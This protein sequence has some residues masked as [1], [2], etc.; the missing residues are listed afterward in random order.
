MTSIIRS[1]GWVRILYEDFIP[2]PWAGEFPWHAGKEPHLN[3]PAQQ[4]RPPDRGRSARRGP[5]AAVRDSELTARYR[6]LFDHLR[7]ELRT[8]HY[9]LKTKKAYAHWLLHFLAFCNGLPPDGDNETAVRSFLTHL[10][11][12]CDVAASTQNQAL[13]ALVFVYREA[14]GRPLELVGEFGKAKRPRRL[15]TVLSLPEVDRLLDQ[16][17]ATNHLLAQLMYGAGLRI[18]DCI[19][20]RVKDLDFYLGQIVVQDGKGGKDRVTVLPECCR[21]LLQQHLGKVQVLFLAD[22]RSDAA[23]VFIWPAL[24][25]KYPAAGKKWVWQYVFPSPKLSQDL[26][27]GVIRRHHIHESKVQEAIAKAADAADIQKRV[28]THTLRHSFAT[29]LLEAGYDIRT[30]QELLGHKDVSTTMIYTHVM[31][32]PGIAVKSPADFD[33]PETRQEPFQTHP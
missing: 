23:S 17:Q 27:S 26:R 13:C 19:R 4:G 3:F 15:P 30:V 16:L 5:A 10:A 21:G 28:T 12:D 1:T 2:A 8:R 6:D 11:N 29:H 22:R 32:R 18:S 7:K 25:R 31:N 24:E 33:P 14:M 20:L 9:A